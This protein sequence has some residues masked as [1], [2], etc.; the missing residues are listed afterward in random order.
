MKSILLTLLITAS[1]T[2]SAQNV[3]INTNTPK[4]TLDVVGSAATANIPDGIIPP[5][6]TRAQLIAKTNYGADQTGAMV[7][8]TD[9]SGTTNT[10]TANVQQPGYYTF[11]GSIW[12]QLRPKFIGFHATK[13]NSFTSP[14]GANTQYIFTAEVYDTNNWFD[15]GTSRFTPKIAGYYQVNASGRLYDGAST[16]RYISLYK[17]GNLSFVGS[18]LYTISVSSVLNVMVYLNGTTDYIDLRLYSANNL[19]TDSDPRQTYFQAY[20][21][22]E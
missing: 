1:I 16:A 3:G 18:D 22:G 17:N 13:N 8:V 21:I 2:A 20:L 15:L 19:T 7:Y 9:I 12:S 5:R 10:A 14:A 4:A 6:L 11:N